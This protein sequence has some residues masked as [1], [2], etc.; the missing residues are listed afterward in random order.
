MP[1]LHERA[2][3][4]WQTLRR[5]GALSAPYFRS[6]EKWRAWAMLIGVIALNLAGVW[7]SKLFTDWYKVFYD[8]LQNKNQ[9]V[10][11]VQMG[12]FMVLAFVSIFIG[13]VTYYLT[14]LLQLRWRA[15]MTRRYMTNWLERRVF[16]R[17]E[18]ARFASSPGGAQTNPD[19]PDQRIQEDM[20]L[21]TSQ[22]LS[23]LMDLLSSVAT[24]VVFV[25]M[26]WT[27]SGQFTLPIAGHVVVIPGF[28]VWVTLVYCIVGSVL[29]HFAGRSLIGLNIRQQRYEADFRHRMIRVR[30][31][32]EAIALEGGEAVERQRL[33]EGFSS[34]LG[35]TLRLIYKQLGLTSFTSSFNQLAVVFPFI[36]AAP[37]FFS[38]AIPLGTLIQISSAFGRV[39]GS[40]SWFVNSYSSLAAWR[41]SVDRLTSF[42]A[43]IQAQARAHA[44]LDHENASDMQAWQLD[45]KLPT[46]AT[47][48]YEATLRVQPGDNVLVQ[49]P[50]G[51]GK[52]TLFRTLAGIWPFARGQVRMPRD[53]MFIPQRPYVPDGRLRD[54][55]AYP[56]PAA[57]YDDAALRQ[58]LQ[59]AL[60]PELADR[61]DDS[62]AWSQKLSGG[63][64]QRL[65]IA[66]VLLRKP[67]WLF[68][69]EATSALDEASE[70]ILYQRLAAQARAAGGALV[71]IAHRPSLAE[72]HAARW[73]LRPQPEGA[74][75]RYRMEVSAG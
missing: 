29:T 2:F 74:D 28:L 73:T 12:R 42:D 64:Q 32:S 16:Y 22:T 18:L 4:I 53:T 48:L 26:L 47:L 44:G 1:S 3:I 52:S 72:Y 9:H 19:N 37:R 20:D 69:D 54:A 71:S 65:A 39:Q 75:A 36:I 27:L 34:V 38:G 14:R 45:V 59:D 61:L 13:L 51:S 50:T 68:A 49:G 11:W 23:L 67:A 46:G 43:S 8:A 63:E 60:L 17:L 6:E 5:V 55:L 56:A 40:L 15:W 10:F 66:R 58:A 57:R 62:D 31:Y 24:L 33:D 25:G 35:N 7:M 30:E 70:K 21:F 41:A